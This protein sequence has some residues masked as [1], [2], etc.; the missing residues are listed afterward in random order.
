MNPLSV[1]QNRYNYIFRLTIALS[2]LAIVNFALVVALFFNTPANYNFN[3]VDFSLLLT[4]GWFLL[5]KVLDLYNRKTIQNKALFVT[6]LKC[7][8]LHLMFFLMY[9]MLKAFAF[10]WKFS[11]AYYTV[12]GA[13]LLLNRYFAALIFPILSRSLKMTAPVALLGVNPTSIR[14]ADY[15]QKHARE[16]SFA[17]FLSKNP[18]SLNTAELVEGF[19]AEIKSAVLAGI[20][21]IY[22]SLAPDKIHDID[23]L[24]TEARNQC[25]RLKFVPDYSQILNK[26]AALD[27]LND[28]QVINLT[29]S[30]V[31]DNM[32]D[33]VVKRLFDIAF[34]LFVI[35]FIFSWLYPILALLIKLESPGPVIFKQERSGRNNVQF[36]CY[37]FRSMRV[38]DDCH[39][40]QASKNDC[41]IT[42]IGRILRKTSLDELPQF[43]NVL[44]GNMS[45]VGPRPHMLKHTE[46]YREVVDQ[47]MVRHYMKPG[48]TGWAQVNGYRG[49]TIELGLMEKRV[50]HDIW[51]MENWSALLD[52]KIVMLTVLNVIKG[53]KNAY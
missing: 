19:K 42:R 9:N 6:T 39:L 7:I 16:Y 23:S 22:I 25:I 41:R 20:N 13:L 10:D 40:K 51:Y 48:I 53:E 18:T 12:L 49:E 44:L 47:Y 2:D 31:Q 15:F 1:M 17:G 26:S 11:V 45:V 21:E 36:Y 27:S 35:I 8:C 38:N 14:L 43:F 32:D 30:C 24:V 5:S 46:H 37:K 33:R 29:G 34:S 4:L 3:Y 50:E 28:F 52:I